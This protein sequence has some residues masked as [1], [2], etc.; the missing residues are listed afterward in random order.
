[1]SVVY[2]ST[3]R[4]KNRVRSPVGP[5]VKVRRKHQAEIVA[6]F[7]TD[8]PLMT[9]TPEDVGFTYGSKWKQRYCTRI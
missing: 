2:D 8:D 3:S 5:A 7:E 1:M 6:D 4:A 9:F